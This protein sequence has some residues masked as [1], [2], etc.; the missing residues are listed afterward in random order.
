MATFVRDQQYSR[1]GIQTV[2]GIPHVKGDWYTGHHREGDEHYIFCGIDIPG[3]TGHNYNNYFDGSDLI[4]HP[5]DGAR[6]GQKRFDHMLGGAVVHMFYRL[7]NRDPFTYAG[8]AVPTLVPDRVP[9]EIRWSF[10]D[11]N[12]HPGDLPDL[13]R[14]KEGAKKRITVNAYERD[15]TAKPRCINRWGTK[16]VVCGFDFGQV[17]GPLGEGFIHVHHLTP[18]HTVGEEYEL[19]P[20][21]DLRPVCPNCHSMLHRKKETLSIQELV[22]LLQ[23]RFDE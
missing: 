12:E 6:V 23:R 9:I 22:G 15:P 11:E 8:R 5:N 17:Y 18:V 4:W 1:E 3:R 16:C 2:L 21:E 20:E 7:A 19:N 13:P 14:L 10:P